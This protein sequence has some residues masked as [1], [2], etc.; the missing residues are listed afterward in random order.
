MVLVVYIKPFKP[1][2]VCTY[3]IEFVW[4]WQEAKAPDPSE[5]SWSNSSLHTVYCLAF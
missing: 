1:R 3:Y 4:H 5:A 2:F